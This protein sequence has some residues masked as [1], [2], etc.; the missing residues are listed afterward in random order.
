MEELY[1]EGKTCWL[2]N[3]PES[4]AR[5]QGQ[6]ELGNAEIRAELTLSTGVVGP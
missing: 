5:N 6:G 4:N 2:Q 1:F 3:S